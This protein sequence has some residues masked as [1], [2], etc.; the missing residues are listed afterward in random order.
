MACFNE[1]TSMV[2]VLLFFLI[3]IVYCWNTEIQ[4]KY[5]NINK[6]I[7]KNYNNDII[8]YNINGNMINSN[9][10]EAKIKPVFSYVGC[11]ND[12]RESRDINEKDFSFITKYNK[13]IP[14]VELCVQLCAN[15]FF[16]IAG[17]Q[18]L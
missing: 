7:N 13:S 12:R 18:A 1:L 6:N 2:Y 14:T 4:Q 11:Y 10:K 9:L 8:N 3:E 16:T 15:D 17:V 5:Q